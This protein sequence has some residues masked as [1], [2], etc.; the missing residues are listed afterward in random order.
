MKLWQVCTNYNPG[1]KIQ[2]ATWFD[3]EINYKW[4]EDIDWVWWLMNVSSNTFNELVGVYK[5]QFYKMYELIREPDWFNY[6]SWIFFSCPRFQFYLLTMDI[7]GYLLRHQKMLHS[8]II[9]WNNRFCMKLNFRSK[10]FVICRLYIVIIHM[11]QMNSYRQFVTDDLSSTIC[12][13]WMSLSL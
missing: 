11:S 10:R 13:R 1:V 6:F 4:E 7:D 5:L 8:L 2:S 9:F 12:H 3:L